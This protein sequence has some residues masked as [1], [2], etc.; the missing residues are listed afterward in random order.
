MIFLRNQNI[1]IIILRIDQ[2]HFVLK[3]VSEFFIKLSNIS[4]C[5]LKTKV[6]CKNTFLQMGNSCSEISV[7][8]KLLKQNVQ[9]I[10]KNKINAPLFNKFMDTEDISLSYKSCAK[11]QIIKHDINFKFSTARKLLWHHFVFTIQEYQKTSQCEGKDI[12]VKH[13]FL[14]YYFANSSEVK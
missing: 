13:F 6:P 3:K 1:I 9:Y 8:K 7:I 12:T 2:L 10:F 4:Y 14:L 5:K 11:H